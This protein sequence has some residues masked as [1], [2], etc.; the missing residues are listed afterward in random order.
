MA[1]FIQ[2]TWISQGLDWAKLTPYKVLLSYP[3][4]DPTKA[5]TVRMIDKNTNQVLFTSQ[6][7][8]PSL[9][10]GDNFSNVV[11]PFNAYSAKGT[12]T[13]ELV[14]VN[15]GRVEDFDYLTENLTLA[16]SGKILIARYGKIYRGDKVYNAQKAGAAGIILFTDPADTAIDGWNRV[17]PET[18]WM[19]PSGVQRGSVIHTMVGDPLTPGYPSTED[20]YRIPVEEAGMPKIPVHPIGYKDAYELLSRMKSQDGPKTPTD[21]KG[22]MNVSY[23]IYDRSVNWY[24][25]NS[26]KICLFFYFLFY[27]LLL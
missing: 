23:A 26:F 27:V 21:W 17:Y 22:Y 7:E 5:N 13:G 24:N 18:W 2:Q 14:Y 11:P 19:P 1:K 15:Y 16:L 25:F 6:K 3:D 12:P 9:Y 10:E 4:L 20:A 8:E